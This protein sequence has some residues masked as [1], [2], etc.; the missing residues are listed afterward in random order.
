MN[1]LLFQKTKKRKTKRPAN[2]NI[3][4]K[5]RAS[6]PRV[7]AEL[8]NTQRQTVN[9]VAAGGTRRAESIQQRNNFKDR[10]KKIKKEQMKKGEKKRKKNNPTKRD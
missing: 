3:R 4:S 8:C 6:Q 10:R 9:Q 7:A 2:Q 1:V 5:T